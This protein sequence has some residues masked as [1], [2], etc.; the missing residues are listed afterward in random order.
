MSTYSP[1]GNYY[2]RA[3]RAYPPMPFD[4]VAVPRVTD[5]I[6]MANGTQWTQRAFIEPTSDDFKK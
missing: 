3:L 6:Y 2:E 5:K 4:P 1:V